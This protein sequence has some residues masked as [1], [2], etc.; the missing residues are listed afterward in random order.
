[1]GTQSWREVPESWTWVGKT[2]TVHFPTWPRAAPRGPPSWKQQHGWAQPLEYQGKICLYYLKNCDYCAFKTDSES[3]NHLIRY[4][5]NS[6]WLIWK[7]NRYFRIRKVIISPLFLETQKLSGFCQLPSPTPR[8]LWDAQMQMV[9]W[10]GWAHEGPSPLSPRSLHLPCG[11]LLHFC[12]G[13]DGPTILSKAV[14]LIPTWVRLTGHSA[15]LLYTVNTT[16]FILWPKKQVLRGSLD[17]PTGY[18]HQTNRGCI[19]GFGVKNL[20]RQTDRCG[21]QLEAHCHSWVWNSEEIS[22][23][24]PGGQLQLK[25]RESWIWKVMRK[26]ET[27]ITAGRCGG[28]RKMTGE[29]GGGVCVC[30]WACAPAHR[31][32]ERAR[33]GQS[34]GRSR[35]SRKARVPSTRAA[36][37]LALPTIVGRSSTSLTPLTRLQMTIWDLSCLCLQVGTLSP[38]H[39]HGHTVCKRQNLHNPGSTP[40]ALC[41]LHGD[42]LLTG[43]TVIPGQAL[44]NLGPVITTAP[45]MCDSSPSCSLWSQVYY[46]RPIAAL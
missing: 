20:L 28:G 21:R 37:Q 9:G 38:G 36:L 5:I 23:T 25:L 16:F 17:L 29:S 2:S 22:D 30:V 44:S 11:V 34:L 43:G 18:F 39:D 3:K 10:T 19:S 4:P 31:G 33:A 24:L 8:G 40:N 45:H 13:N 27:K 41:S 42:P 1:M 15:K 14:T 6:I 12:P 46:C 32:R 35:D 26:W 7:L